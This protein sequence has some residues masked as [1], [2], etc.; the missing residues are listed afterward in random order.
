[1]K[2][3]VERSGRVTCLYDERLDLTALGPCSVTRASYV[4]PVG[5]QWESRIRGGPVLGPFP[6]RSDAVA[7]EVRY[8]EE[9]L[10]GGD[11]RHARGP[12]EAVGE[13]AH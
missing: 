6:R 12:R 13:G 5:S 10:D 7:A 2:L 11:V 1:M 8:L 3:L 9:R 4:E